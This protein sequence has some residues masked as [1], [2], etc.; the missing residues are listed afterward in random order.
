MER[1]LILLFPL[2]VPSLLRAKAQLGNQGFTAE[3]PHEWQETKCWSHQ[4]SLPRGT[5]AG[6]WCQEPALGIKPKHCSMGGRHFILGLNGLL[7]AF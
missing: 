2:Q 1:V 6:F 5:L 7:S 3:L 4:P